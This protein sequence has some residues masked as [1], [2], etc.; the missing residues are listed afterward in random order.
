MAHGTTGGSGSDD[1]LCNSSDIVPIFEKNVNAVGC[2]IVHNI[3]PDVAL[4]LELDL[5]KVKHTPKAG[6]R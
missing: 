6:L 5:N 1:G 2:T 3:V 4:L